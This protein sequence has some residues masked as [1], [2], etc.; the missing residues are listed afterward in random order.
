MD[1]KALDLENQ[2]GIAWDVRRGTPLAIGQ[3]GGNRETTFT[4]GSHASDA[5][6]PALDHFANAEFER[7]RLSLLV[8]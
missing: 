4:P 8:G 1:T 6:I 3:T 7:E 2:V 5:D